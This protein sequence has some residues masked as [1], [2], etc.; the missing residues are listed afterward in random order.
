MNKEQSP[1]Q[2]AGFLA[3]FFGKLAGR[4]F[5][6]AESV[7]FLLIISKLIGDLKTQFDFC[8]VIPIS[9]KHSC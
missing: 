4:A 6:L 7:K 1:I 2:L 5:S 8:V 9:K 3:A